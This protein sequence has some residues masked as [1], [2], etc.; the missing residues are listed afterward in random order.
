MFDVIVVGAGPAGSTA[1][2]ALA[3]LGCRVLLAERFAMPRYKSCSGQLIKK[4]LDLAERY[5]GEQ[6]PL[7]VTCAPSENRGMILS[8]GYGRVTRFEQ[9]GL[10]VWRSSFDKWL[11]DKAAASG[12]VVR[13]NTDVVSCVECDGLVSVTLKGEKTYVEETRYVIVCEGA[14]GSLKRKLLGCNVPRVTTYQTFNEGSI[15]LDYHYFY[16]YLQPELSEYD[17]WFNVKDNQL[18]LGV[19]VTD[20]NNISHYYDR[21]IAYMKERHGLRI[22]RQLK[23]D[24]WLMPRI[25][26]GCEIDHGRGRVLF[27]GEIAGFLNPM[28]EGVSAAMESGHHAATAVATHFDDPVQA[29]AVYRESVASLRSYMQRQW[30][31]IGSVSQRF[32]EMRLPWGYRL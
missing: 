17:A 24:K 30:G 6:V 27:A 1:A 3:D 16:A 2:K 21:F 4:S 11:A 32:A 14:A 18:V 22:E 10:N 28:G 5:F 29:L 25:Q 7:S 8:D 12:A 9:K 20:K 26:P 19:C 15:E 13:D 23:V 31:F